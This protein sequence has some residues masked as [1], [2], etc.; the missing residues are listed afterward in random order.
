MAA[1]NFRN[2]QFVFKGH[3]MSDIAPDITKFV[4]ESFNTIDEMRILLLLCRSPEKE[5]DVWAVSSMLYL[6]P[7]IAT[8]SLANLQEKGLLENA[9]GKE[10]VYQYAPKDTRVDGLVHKVIEI[11]QTQPVTLINLVY[12]RPKGVQAFADAF[13]IRKDSEK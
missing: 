4:Q 6:K 12:S 7:D 9:P 13:R 5:W 10:R 3:S 1:W 11:D 8:V 2:S